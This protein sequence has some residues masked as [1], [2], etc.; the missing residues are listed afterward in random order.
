MLNLLK[1]N[2]KGSDSPT[3]QAGSEAKV[4]EASEDV[5]A[6]P[7]KKKKSTDKNSTT[8]KAKKG[9]AKEGMKTAT[10]ATTNGNN[11]KK[12]KKS[13]SS[14]SSMQTSSTS[15]ISP[16]PPSSSSS[17]E[18]KKTAPKRTRSS[19]TFVKKTPARSRS[20][21]DLMIQRPPP[22]SHHNPEIDNIVN[23]FESETRVN[24]A[25]NSKLAEWAK[26]NNS[27]DSKSEHIPRTRVN[28]GVK[29]SVTSLNDTARPGNICRQHT[30]QR[31]RS[32]SNK[33][34][35]LDS[36]SA[37]ARNTSRGQGSMSAGLD[38]ASEHSRTAGGRRISRAVTPGRQRSKSLSRKERTPSTPS[39]RK[40]VDEQLESLS[41]GGS[42]L[43]SPIAALEKRKGNQEEA[44]DAKKKVEE[45][46]AQLKAM[47]RQN[48][49]LQTVNDNLQSKLRIQKL[50]SDRLL[51]ERDKEIKELNET[52]DKIMVDGSRSGSS[53]SLVAAIEKDLATI[54]EQKNQIEIKL[55]VANDKL[56]KNDKEWESKM[57][58]KDETIDHLMQQLKKVKQKDSSIDG[59]E[60][61]MPTGRARKRLNAS[62]EDLL[63]HNNRGPTGSG[64][65]RQGSFGCLANYANDVWEK[66]SPGALQNNKQRLSREE[67]KSMASAVR[68]I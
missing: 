8:V 47:E 40:S 59:S 21:E 56:A 64:V 1:R 61:K 22:N 50:D 39:R 10:Q 30:P 2:T 63:H 27:L 5:I 60:H 67:R 65:P 57:K 12:K 23:I 34:G 51:E 32:S 41:S 31:R 35:S 45:L 43:F 29:R 38:S 13:S 26:R 11:S 58:F 66:V 44:E 17:V 33:C 37:H 55:K 62:S 42:F 4:Y 7:K 25:A 19:D 6:K 3:T 53:N 16:S 18:K 46:Q 54:K 9:Y 49:A 15:S 28:S 24:R 36:K 52:V 14:N 48:H 68:A 20:L